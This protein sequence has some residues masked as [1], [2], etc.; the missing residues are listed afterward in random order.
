ML[1]PHL[2]L[3]ESK[4]DIT[5]SKSW[6]MQSNMIVSQLS[7]GLCTELKRMGHH[8]MQNEFKFVTGQAEDSTAHEH[9]SISLLFILIFFSRLEDHCTDP[10]CYKI[11]QYQRSFIMFISQKAH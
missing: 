4:A 8:R 1:I 10:A 5:V 6:P 11:L 7:Y 2:G 9:L 3:L